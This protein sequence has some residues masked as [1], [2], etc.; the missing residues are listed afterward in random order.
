MTEIKGQDDKSKE[1]SGTTDETNALHWSAQIIPKNSGEGSRIKVNE[2]LED[3]LPPNTREIEQSIDQQCSQAIGV[4]NT[5]PELF[6]CQT[7]NQSENS[8]VAK[9][10]KNIS[11]ESEFS[12]FTTG[13]GDRE[14]QDQSPDRSA[15]TSIDTLG[16]FFDSVSPLPVDEHECFKFEWIRLKSF[17]DWPLN[18]IFSIVLARNGWVSLGDGDRARCYS[19]YA[20][21]EGW[22]IGD[23]P[24]QYHSSNCRFRTGQSNNIPIFRARSTEMSTLT[25]T[26]ETE[27]NN[28]S[29]NNKSCQMLSVEQPSYEVMTT[30]NICQNMLS[31][32]KGPFSNNSAETYST[33]DKAAQL[34]APKSDPMGI[35]FDRPKYPSYSFH[36]IRISS[37]SD[38]PA[39]MTQTPVEMALAGFFYAGYGDYTRCFCCGGGLR[40]WE[41]GDDPWVS[42]LYL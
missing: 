39:T 5:L 30:S 23:D 9:T 18:S 35:K 4:K 34:E 26:Q 24:D 19:C 13:E 12:L 16:S 6:A 21:H 20:V 29:P 11:S 8:H 37:Y 15:L 14:K 36:G 40:N 42:N 27:T 2:I 38:W 33:H 7:G 28:G 10:L 1:K 3:V 25:L 22:R 41:A 31:T 32:Q 17:L